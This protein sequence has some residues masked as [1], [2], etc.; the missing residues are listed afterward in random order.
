MSDNFTFVWNKIDMLRSKTIP[1]SQANRESWLH[2]GMALAF[3]SRLHC[4]CCEAIGRCARNAA[5]PRPKRRGPASREH[6]K[7]GKIPNKKS[8]VWKCDSSSTS[9]VQGMD[10][11]VEIKHTFD[12]RITLVFDSSK[13]DNPSIWQCC[14]GIE[15]I[16]ARKSKFRRK[17]E[18]VELFF[19]I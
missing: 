1:L 3:P 17:I 4:V 5:N 19:A 2:F 18:L 10:K 13:K 7:K 9:H 15:R 11:V 6:S 8:I 16:S 14:S 12:I